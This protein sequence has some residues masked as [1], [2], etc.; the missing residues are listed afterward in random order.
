MGGE[1]L[2]LWRRPGLKRAGGGEKKATPAVE[3]GEGEKR[4]EGGRG[5]ASGDLGDIGGPASVVCKVGRLVGRMKDK[6]K[7]QKP[8][9]RR[10]AAAKVR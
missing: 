3:R 4:E 5:A 9:R 6:Q 10:K 8:E 2:R 7:R 1:G